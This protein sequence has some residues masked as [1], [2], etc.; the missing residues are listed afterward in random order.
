MKR[1]V[2]RFFQHPWRSIPMLAILLPTCWVIQSSR[3]L[4]ETPPKPSHMKL[5]I[6]VYSGD[7]ETVWN[8]FRFGNFALNQGDLVK[9]F[10]LAKGVEAE[11]L[12]SDKFKVTDMMNEFARQGGQIFACG[13][14]L[15]VRHSEGSK[16]CPISTMQ[17]MYDIVK[18]SDKVVTF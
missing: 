8:A 2:V 17:D 16:L 3:T 18:Q 10:L 12:D 4:A 5:G 1:I 15:R 7:A 9:V 14:C 6:V 13:T 11:S